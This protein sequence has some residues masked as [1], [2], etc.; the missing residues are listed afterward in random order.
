MVGLI[1]IFLGIFVGFRGY[2]RIDRL[3]KYEFEH[4]TDGGVVQFDSYENSKKHESGKAIGKIIIYAGI[5]IFWIG[6]FM[7]LL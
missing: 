5:L 1:V 6:L 3:R 4:T 7:L 2:K